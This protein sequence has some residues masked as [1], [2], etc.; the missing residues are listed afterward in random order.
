M[1]VQEVR[2][3]SWHQTSRWIYF[4]VWYNILVNISAE[5]GEKIDVVKHSFC[6]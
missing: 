5:T 3:D 2:W 4:I 1:G 6:E